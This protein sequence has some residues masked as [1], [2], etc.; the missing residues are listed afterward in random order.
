MEVV[1]RTQLRTG[2]PVYPLKQVPVTLTVESKPR[3]VVVQFALLSTVNG[4]VTAGYDT[5][6]KKKYRKKRANNFTKRNKLDNST[7]N[8]C[9]MNISCILLSVKKKKKK[10]SK[11]RNNK[12]KNFFIL[13]LVLFV[14][15]CVLLCFVVC[16]CVCV[17]LLLLLL[18]FLFFD[19]L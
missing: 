7:Y 12:F 14:F 16:V 2:V 5:K 9:I 8:A 15:C 11:E 13:F 10:K 18:L 17:C 19:V 4:Q 3:D 6:K 1:L